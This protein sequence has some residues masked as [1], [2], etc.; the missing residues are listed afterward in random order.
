MTN[1]TIGALI[2]TRDS[3]MHI[4]AALNSITHICSQIV[5]VDTGSKDLTPQI[6]AKS[7]AEVYFFKWIDDFSA[8]RNFALK[9]LYTDWVFVLDSDE[10]LD[11]FNL[12]EFYKFLEDKSIG[13]INF[14][15]QNHISSGGN[16]AVNTHRY[17][18]L[19]INNPQIRFEGKIHEQIRGSIER[20]NYNIIESDFSI[21]HFGYDKYNESK[22]LRN[23]NLL[24]QE[25]K[26]NPAD[27]WI[28][29]HLA[30]THYAAGRDSEANN[31]YM[32]ILNSPLLSIIQ[33]E[34]TN[35]RLA[36]I[37]LKYDRFDQVIK[38][39]DFKSSDLQNEALRNYVS[40]TAY[41]CL[42]NYSKAIECFENC[43]N[44]NSPAL[45]KGDIEKALKAAESLYLKN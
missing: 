38:I 33:K 2:L 3:G 16:S 4:Q 1:I 29:Y 36:Q 39:T 34:M 9:H 42:Q 19:F 20:N 13:G 25:L 27:D 14:I 45:N 40:G 7:G 5:V 35:L 43:L 18:R 44:L 23:L 10:I 24:E 41:L 28:K 8:A 26:E 22:N 32:E 17:T 6:A 37:A 11:S 15:I 21:I 31:L 12:H 30:E